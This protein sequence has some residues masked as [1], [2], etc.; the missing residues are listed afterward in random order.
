MEQH[1][2]NA[3]TVFTYNSEDKI[4]GGVTYGGYS[5]SIVVGE[6]FVLRVPD[7]L[8]PAGA[9]PLLCAGITTYS[10]LRHWKVSKGQ[11]VGIVGLGGLGHMGLKFAHAFGAH[12]V[13]FTTSAHKIDDAKRLGADE[14][15]ISKN[16]GFVFAGF[17]VGGGE[18]RGA[19]TPMLSPEASERTLYLR[20]DLTGSFAALVTPGDAI[21]PIEE[22]NFIGAVASDF[23]MHFLAATPDLGDVIFNTPKALTPEAIDEE[24]VQKHVTVGTAEIQWNLYEWGAGKLGLVNILPV[25][26]GGAVAHGPGPG[27]PGVRLAGITGANGHGR[28]SVQRDV[29]S[30][31]RR[32]AWAWGEPYGPGLKSYRGLYVRDMVAEETKRVGGA[33]AIYQTMN[34]EGSRIFYLENEELYVYDYETGTSLDLTAAH[35]PGESTGGVQQ[36]VSD[37]SENGDYVYFVA[38]GVLANGGVSGEDNLYL[39]HETES[40]W[41]ITYITTLSPADSPDWI[42]RMGGNV[43]ALLGISSRVSPDGRYLAFMSS[44]PLTGYDNTDAASGEPDEEVYLY[45]ARTEKLVCASC[46]PT[47][48]RPVGV[49]DSPQTELLVDRT[50]VWTSVVSSPEDP[51][52]NHW[53]AGSVPGWD[54]LDNNP[55]T[56]QPRYLSDDGRLFFDSPD[57]LVPRDTNGLEDVYEFEPV[58]EGSC[59]SGVPSGD[60]VY[61]PASEGCVGLISSG[62]SSSESAFFDASENG[63]DVFFDTTGRLVGAD[64]DKSF[65][66]YD[67]HVCGGEGVACV[68]APV[69]A[70]PCEEGESCKAAPTP[71]PEIFG[72]P[73]STTF[74]GAGNVTPT[75]TGPAVNEGDEEDCQMQARLC[76]ETRQVRGAAQIFSQ[77]KG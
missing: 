66:V 37:V 48:A 9:A 39:A 27:V 54:D 23:E 42:E 13:L 35:A 29:S 3:A 45:D 40:G 2:D 16:P 31:G 74:N 62:T 5:E 65:D 64:Y 36:L 53:L 77:A 34:S 43:P 69:S 41:G 19:G 30:D 75:P 33:H 7:G 28:G 50:G 46:D 58:G 18:P 8:D 63:D 51:R 47:G 72:P 61:S 14:V 73:P 24:T 32:V 12:T 20:D 1:C 15:V 4:L 76:E 44:R 71:Q 21:T 55:S 70:P 60:A 52:T 57:A 22:P 56:Y 6:N 59:S 10:P 25:D 38:K 26:E 11:K 68:Q 49:L 67:A 17:V